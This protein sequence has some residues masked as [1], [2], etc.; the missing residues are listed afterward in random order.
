[1]LML[2]KLVLNLQKSILLNQKYSN[3]MSSNFDIVFMT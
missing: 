3:Q 2:L 1:M